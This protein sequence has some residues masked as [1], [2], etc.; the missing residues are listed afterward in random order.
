MKA[1]F[2]EKIVEAISKGILPVDFSDGKGAKVLAKLTEGVF[3]C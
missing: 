1:P 2:D 3:V